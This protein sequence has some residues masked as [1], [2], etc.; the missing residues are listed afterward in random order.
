MKEVRRPLSVGVERILTLI[1][2]MIS[3]KVP[4]EKALVTIA[5]PVANSRSESAI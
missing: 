5:I 2:P 1:D 3:L 4:S